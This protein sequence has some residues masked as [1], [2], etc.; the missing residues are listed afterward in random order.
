MEWHNILFITGIAFV[1][2]YKTEFQKHETI[3]TVKDKHEMKHLPG[4]SMTV[5][6]P[7]AKVVIDTN[8]QAFFNVPMYPLKSVKKAKFIDAQLQIGKTYKIE[9]RGNRWGRFGPNIYKVTEIT[10]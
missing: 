7:P 10:K 3:I 1:I 8:G 4:S 6:V 2:G 5:C 9:T